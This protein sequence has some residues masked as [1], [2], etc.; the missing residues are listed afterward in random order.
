MRKGII[1]AGGNGTRLA[2]LTFAVSKQ[3]M[4]VYDKPMIYYPITTLMMAGIKEF[5]LITNK[6]HLNSFKYLLKDG[7]QWGV[8]FQYAIQEK[9]NGIAEALIIGEEFINNSPIALILGDNLFHGT[10]LIE[11]L[12]DANQQDRGGTIFAYQVSD[13]NRYGVVEFNEKKE[14]L[15]IEEKPKKP[16]SFYAVTGLYFYDETANKRAKAI[17]PS[18][19]GELEITALN[20]SYLREKK[21]QVKTFGRGMTWLDTGTFDSLHE[22]SSYIKTIEHRQGLKVGCPEEIAWRRG[23][24]DEKQLKDLAKPLNKSGY[25]SYLTSLIKYKRSINRFGIY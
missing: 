7:S 9:P 13:P 15:S 4:S 18:R 22:A 10:G 5:L 6:E 1:L 11:T 23:W 21:L 14:A 16:K 20:N 8:N 17:I 3:L 12:I 19:R 2:P 24:I 25:G